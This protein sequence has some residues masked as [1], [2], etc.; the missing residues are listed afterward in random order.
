VVWVGKDKYNSLDEA[1][2]DSENG[3]TKWMEESF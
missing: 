3:L 1:L 2:E